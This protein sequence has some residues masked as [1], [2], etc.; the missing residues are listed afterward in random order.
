MLYFIISASSS[1]PEWLQTLATDLGTL[2][3]IVLFVGAAYGLVKWISKKFRD[4]VRDLIVDEV[5]PIRAEF[6]NNGGSSVKDTIDRL[7]AD[8]KDL[9]E[10]VSHL[11]ND[12]S[13]LK[14]DVDYIKSDIDDIADKASKDHQMLAAKIDKIE[15]RN[16]EIWRE[17]QKK[18]PAYGIYE[19]HLEDK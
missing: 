4:E 7:G 19:A 12:M 10:N 11:R 5:Q 9:K 2:W 13:H 8:Y 1:L 17:V 16:D 15:K 18:R 14:N 6:Q 3:P